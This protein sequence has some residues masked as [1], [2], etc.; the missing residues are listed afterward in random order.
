[1]AD[2][3]ATRSGSGIVG[4]MRRLTLAVVVVLAL[5]ACGSGGD[6]GAEPD[7]AFVEYTTT[8]APPGRSFAEW[9]AATRSICAVF[10]PQAQA[11]AA[12]LPDR[13]EGA[14]AIVDLIDSMLPLNEEY[15]AALRAVPIP[16]ERTRSVEQMHERLGRLETEVMGIR[17]AAE[18]VDHTAA[19]ASSGRMLTVSA[20]LDGLLA[21]LGL[22]ECRTPA[23]A[24]VAVESTGDRAAP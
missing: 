14:Q 1:M 16:T 18:R 4:A 11:L 8:T 23:S 9:Q 19:V 3:W 7:D 6:D 13:V 24:T 5:G 20:E 12:S 15:L 21:D 17:A 22:P 10:E 2:R